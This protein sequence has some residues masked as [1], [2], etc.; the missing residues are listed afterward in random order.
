MIKSALKG[1][2]GKKDETEFYKENLSKEY[3]LKKAED[4]EE[5]RLLLSIFDIT[6]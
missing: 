1:I 2:F 5:L 6:I 3:I 4:I